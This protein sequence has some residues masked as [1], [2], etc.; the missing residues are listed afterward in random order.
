[1]NGKEAGDTVERDAMLILLTVLAAAAAVPA[2]QTATK[3]DDPIICKRQTMGSEVGT[4]MQAKKKCMRQSDWDY[5]AKQEKQAIQQLVNDGD[6]RMAAP[7][8]PPH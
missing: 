5:M 1:M 2:A 3:Q 4:R 8:G 7:T 6:A